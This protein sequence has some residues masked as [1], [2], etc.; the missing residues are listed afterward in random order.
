MNQRNQRQ[1]AQDVFNET[2]HFFGTKVTF[3][4]AFPQVE[5]C[6]V[7][8]KESGDVEPEWFEDRI[9][10]SPG[11]Y[12]NCSNPRCYNGGFRVG[13]YIRDMVEK[14]ETEREGSAS[15]QGNEGSPKGRRISGPC[16]NLFKYK[17]CI[18]YKTEETKLGKSEP[19]AGPTST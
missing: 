15:C 10:R 19:Q 11:E 6:S 13:M 7:S 17:I 14:R 18:R 8:V 16:M 4:E 5:E 3:A 12:I 9:E 1:K 2:N